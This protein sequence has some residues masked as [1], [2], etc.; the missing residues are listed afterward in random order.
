MLTPIQRYNRAH[1]Q[2]VLK[3]DH[4]QHIEIRQ[5]WMSIASSYAFLVRREERLEEEDAA[6]QGRE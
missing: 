5:L 6:R 1:A 2:C 3:A 4:S